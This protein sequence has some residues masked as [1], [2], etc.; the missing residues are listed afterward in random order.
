MTDTSHLDELV[1]QWWQLRGKG[2]PVMPED[3]CKD[4]PELLPALRARLPGLDSPEGPF[5]K[6]SK[7]TR[8]HAPGGEHT[9]GLAPDSPALELPFLRPA[10]GPDELGR[11]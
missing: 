4:C 2:V 3:L 5:G 9:L 8:S 1:A 10:E 6:H 11:L 7:M